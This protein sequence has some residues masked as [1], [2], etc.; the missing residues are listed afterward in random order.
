MEFG[1]RRREQD[2]LVSERAFDPARLGHSLSLFS[3]SN[4]ILGAR[5]GPPEWPDGHSTILAGAFDRVPLS[6]HE[7][8]PG[9]AEHTDTRLLG[10]GV[11]GIRIAIDAQPVD[12]TAT[13]IVSTT[14]DLDLRTASL[15]RH[16]VWQLA[17]GRQIALSSLRFVPLLGRAVCVQRHEITLIDFT[18][19]VALEFPVEMSRPGGADAGD[20]RNSAR[21]R[22]IPVA[23]QT[24]AE[25]SLWRFAAGQEQQ[26]LLTAAQRLSCATPGISLEAHRVARGECRPGEPLIVDRH[27]ELSL[28]APNHEMGAEARTSAQSLDNLFE[29]HRSAV[30][31]FW[32]GMALDLPADPTLTVALRYNLLQ[33]FLSASRTPEMGTAAKGLS[34]EGYEGHSFWDNEV[35]VLPMLALSSPE[36]ARNALVWRIGRLD[37]AR[38][39]ARSVGHPRGALF[40]WRT[41]AGL[42]CS[43]HYPTGAAQ[44]HVNAA[45]AYA[46]EVYLWATGD[47]SILTDGAAELLV[48]TARLWFD[49]GHF[50]ERRGGAFLIHGVTGPDEYT[51]LVDNDFY[52]N[53]MARRHLLFAAR[54]LE[55]LA[56]DDPQFQRLL[57]E[58]LGIGPSEAGEWRRAAD[59]MWLPIDPALRVHPQDDTFLDK[60]LLPA[61]PESTD[62]PAPLLMQLHP[63]ILFRHRIS[64]QGDVVQAHV[65]AGLDASLAQIE[66]DLEFYEPLTTHD[67]T[68]SLPAFAICASWLGRDEK[69][70]AYWRQTALVDL[71]DLHGNTDHGL[72]MAAMAGSWL[73]LAC[74]WAGLRLGTDQLWL[75]P[76]CPR[77]WPGYFFRFRWHGRLIEVAVSPASTRYTL[78]EGKP[79]VLLDHGRSVELDAQAPTTVPPPRTKAVIFDLDGVLTDT[80][81]WHFQAWKRL[82]DEHAI[83]FDRTVNESL[84]GVDRHNSLRRILEA[85]ETEVDS[86]DFEAM[87]AQKNAYYIDSIRNFTPA[88]LFPGAVELLRDC[89]LAG[90]RIGLASASRNAPALIER[91]GIA[92]W[93]DH[94]TNSATICR[95]KPDPEIFL[96][97]ARALGVAPENCVAI[98]D[99]SAGI[100]A[101]RSAG[102]A[103]IGV[104]GAA[105]LPEADRVFPEIG[106]IGLRDIVAPAGDEPKLT[107]IKE[108]EL[109]SNGRKT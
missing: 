34:G 84:K 40:P 55:R 9:F 45:I 71:D 67:S 42:E 30:S 39:N 54:V 87:Q 104:G 18:A 83:P 7:R 2:W 81:E 14:C 76:R 35:F 1:S 37:Q 51:A 26:L 100:A 88:D 48:E 46:L 17:D 5:G 62:R 85:A 28:E 98:E 13:K 33:V 32:R 43:T 47:R 82:A 72:H 75:A 59:L 29:A 41:I 10:P 23:E 50:S 93:F 12:F 19:E 91:L 92:R 49:L 66:R 73:V 95:G 36:V 101:I 77:D 74:G 11:T 78:L 94:I 6:Y 27:V 70:T 64:K 21:A 16:T 68:L 106:A 31:E 53:A 102:M 80:A 109:R 89:R 52:T 57:A 38:A 24:I 96:E 4:G 103:S 108:M 58:R 25:A 61:S 63:M 107:R 79:L 3:L 65:T 8:F 99:A 15:R 22:F 69:A 97:T 44:Y 20:P 60:P 90:L 56:V 105:L 86:S